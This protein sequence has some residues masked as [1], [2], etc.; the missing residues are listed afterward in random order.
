MSFSY[1]FYGVEFEGF[2]KLFGSQDES[3]IAPLLQ[4]ADEYDQRHS[5]SSDAKECIS[6]NLSVLKRL[7]H[8][9]RFS[10]E[11]MMVD[12]FDYVEFLTLLAWMFGPPEKEGSDPLCDPRHIEDIPVS[13]Q[14]FFDMLVGSDPEIDQLLLYIKKGRGFLDEMTDDMLESFY[15]YL[16]PQEVSRCALFMNKWAENPANTQALEQYSEYSDEIMQ[17]FDAC[18]QE[19]L[20]IFLKMQP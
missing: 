5:S 20:G 16:T 19:E 3:Q 2:K 17:H 8:G 18:A 1:G 4:R 12:D 10:E 15:A 9:D 6:E 11:E 7:I 14:I 13:C